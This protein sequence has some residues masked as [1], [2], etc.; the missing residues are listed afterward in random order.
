MLLKTILNHVEPF[1]GFVYNRA[2]LKES[3]RE[4]SCPEPSI[5][6]EIRERIGSK[7]VCGKCGQKGPGY[8]RLPERLFHYLPI[9]GIACFFAYSRRRVN[10]KN[11]GVTAE[12]IPWAEGNSQITNTL[13]WYLAS[14]ARLLS[15]KTV[16]T[17]FRVG[18]DTV[19]RCVEQAVNWGLEQRDLDGI[20]GIGIDEIARAKGHRYLTLVY[21]ISGSTKRLLWIGSWV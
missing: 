3:H 5:V 4:W 18:W 13:A 9:L 8:D 1:K 10:C 12:W 14:W 7:P 16:A 11:C 15:W 17:R 2:N 20:T 6:I 21:Q 19:Y